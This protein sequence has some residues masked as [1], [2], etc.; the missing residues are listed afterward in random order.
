M[1]ISCGI[2]FVIWIFQTVFFMMH[3]EIVL[4]VKLITVWI[5]LYV[6]LRFMIKYC[7]VNFS[8][9]ITV[10]NVKMNSTG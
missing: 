9:S 4:N 5:I 1:D 8:N 2:M 3:K 10:F 6:L 7:S